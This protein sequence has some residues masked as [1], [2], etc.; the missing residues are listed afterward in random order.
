[1][2]SDVIALRVEVLAVGEHASVSE[3]TRW[4]GGRAVNSKIT[5]NRTFFVF[6]AL[7]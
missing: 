1:M 6:N 4:Q 7:S 2:L 5:T 3:R